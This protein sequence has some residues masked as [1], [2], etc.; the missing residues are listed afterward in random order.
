MSQVE[1]SVKD[2]EVLETSRPQ[3]QLLRICYRLGL[4]LGGGVFDPTVIDPQNV[5]VNGRL[6]GGIYS[7]TERM[8]MK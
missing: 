6:T 7:G 3:T 5:S 8:S 4:S 2:R 1:K